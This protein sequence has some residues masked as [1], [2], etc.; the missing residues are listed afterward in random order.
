VSTNSSGSDKQTRW[1]QTPKLRPATEQHDSNGHNRYSGPIKKAEER[2][3]NN[4][5]RLLVATAG[6]LI[7]AACSDG[8]DSVTTNPYAAAEMWI[9]KPGATSNRCLELDQTTTYI[10]SDNSV[11]VFD[12]T[13]AVD[14]GFDCFYVYPTVDL[15]EEPGNTEDLT[16]VSLV[17][18]PLDNQAA[19]FTELCNV[20]APLYHQMTIGSYDVPGGFRNSEYFSRAFT[21]VEAAFDQYLRESGNRPFVLIGH[22]QGSHM[23]L[24]LMEKRFDQDPKLR[25]RMI[26]ALLI[27]PT[28]NLRVPAG[29]IVGGT[30]EN[31]PLCTHATDTGCIVAY[32]S[33]AAGGLAERDPVSVPRPCVNPTL[34]GGNPG[35]LANTIWASNL[36]LP[37]PPTVE[38][39]F[40]AYPE[41]H[42]AECE[43][44]GFLALDTLPEERLPP[45]STQVLEDVLGGSLHVPDMSFGMGDLLRL[46][47]TQSEQLR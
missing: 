29:E 19:R 18:R 46:V 37:L 40:A 47:A 2:N 44:D 28:G 42:T 12:H 23:L 32:D 8:S 9:C 43:A 34:L 41:L 16:D 14:P 20:Y 1:Q 30:F 5:Q 33:V 36:G 11:A 21:D 4:L 10:Y 45:L 25:Q 24:A 15:R 35:I 38:T 17:L 22:S 6:P 3:M 26:S 39:P 7:L 13:P 27:G 31:I